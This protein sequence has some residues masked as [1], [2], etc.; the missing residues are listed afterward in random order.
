MMWYADDI[1]ARS[2]QMK[3]ASHMECLASLVVVFF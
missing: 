2:R 3:P 1:L